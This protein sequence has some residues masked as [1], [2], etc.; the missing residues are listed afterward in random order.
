MIDLDGKKL[1]ALARG[2]AMFKGIENSGPQK[3]PECGGRAWRTV[4][5][6][7]P[8]YECESCHA[9][10]PL[11]E[12]T[13]GKGE[14]FVCGSTGSDVKEYPDA[15]YY[16]RAC[17]D[18]KFNLNNSTQTKCVSCDRLGSIESM[19]KNEHGAGYLCRGCSAEWNSSDTY[20]KEGPFLKNTSGLKRGASKYGSISNE[21]RSSY[22]LTC[23]CSH[24]GSEH[25]DGRGKCSK[26]GCEGFN[27]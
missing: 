1:A 16:C 21:D 25:Y 13:N 2:V 15:M 18:R 6:G 19:N 17:G 24:K 11:P 12:H 8:T 22:S 3:C 10:F 23:K 4:G 5:N 20:S 14:C 27:K 26:C 9:E 7:R